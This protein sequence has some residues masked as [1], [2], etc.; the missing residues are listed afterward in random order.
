MP[1]DEQGVLIETDHPHHAKLKKLGRAYVKVRKVWT[2]S[3]V[4][5][6]EAKQRLIDAMK[7][8]K[9]EH[10]KI[11]DLDIELKKGKDG[12]KVTTDSDDDEDEGE[13]AE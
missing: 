10:F 8:A 13:D 3:R 12:L 7:E 11:D 4:P 6:T 1:K 9:L 2:D 5:V